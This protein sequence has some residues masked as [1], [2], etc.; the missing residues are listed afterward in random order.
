MGNYFTSCE[1]F[2]END[3]SKIDARGISL[4]NGMYISFAECAEHWAKM[5]SCEGS[6]CIG[7]RDIINFTFTFY[8]LPKPIVIKF[9]KK[10]SFFEFF[11]RCNTRQ[12]FHNLQKSIVQN[13]Y[14][15]YDMT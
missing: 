6:T 14:C 11:S 3:I 4:K 12:R 7:E 2:T 8:A 1:L 15:T 10:R 9:I 13:G 5:N